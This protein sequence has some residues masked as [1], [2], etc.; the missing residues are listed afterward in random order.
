MKQIDRSILD[1]HKAGV[2]V[3]GIAKQ[4][5][6][7]E[8]YILEVLRAKQQGG[9]TKR[10]GSRITPEDRDEIIAKY[11]GGKPS[12]VIAR[13]TGRGTSTILRILKEAGLSP[14]FLGKEAEVVERRTDE[15][16]R[17]RIALNHS[18]RPRRILGRRLPPGAGRCSSRRAI[19]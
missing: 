19:L 11:V 14:R 8:A 1:L 15:G 12:T 18:P 7:Q 3:F 16:A 9:P 5:G 17:V 2:S 4:T 10:M 6:A 13:E